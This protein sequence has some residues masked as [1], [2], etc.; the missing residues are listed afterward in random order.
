MNRL[1]VAGAA[2]FIAAVTLVPVSASAQTLD[3]I[4]QKHYAARGGYDKIKAIQT[5]KI[6]QTIGTP[7]SR[8][9]MA[10][11]KKRPGLVRWEVTPAGQT[12]AIPR[13]IN[14]EGGWDTQQ[15]KVVPRPEI[16]LKEDRDI[17]ADI[18][19][20]LV[21]W[22]AKGHTLTLEGTEKLGTG[23]A[24]RLKL[25]TRNGVTREIFLDTKTFLPVMEKGRMSL[26]PDPRGNPRFNEHVFTYSDWR[27]VNGVKFPFAVDEERTGGPITQSFA[28]YVE[29]ID[30]NM[31]ADDGIFQ[32]QTPKF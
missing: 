23:Q 28:V 16:M 2:V 3:E 13:V 32:L 30:T 4:V 29:K 7:F 15:G 21:D 20:P 18:D 10:I 11:V 27:D 8:T 31:P 14:A 1:S 26:P 24:Y 22:K 6:S 9:K 19:G 25:V 5:L 12:A 17:D